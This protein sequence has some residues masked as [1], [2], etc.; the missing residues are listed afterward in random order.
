[1]FKRKQRGISPSRNRGQIAVQRTLNHHRTAV[2][3]TEFKCERFWGKGYKQRGA[4]EFVLI[5]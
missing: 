4:T 2:R 5:S 3:E 1:M